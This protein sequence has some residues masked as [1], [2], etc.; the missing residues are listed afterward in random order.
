MKICAAQIRP[1]K[2]DIQTNIENHKRLIELAFSY[3][4]DTIIFP[5]LSLTGY[6]P[7]LAKELAINE[8]D[9][10]LN[11]FQSMSDD[12]GVTIGVGVP[13]KNNDGICISMILFHPESTRQV[14]S[15]KYLHADE[16]PF[17]VSGR[18][19]AVLANNKNNIALAICYE[20]SVPEHSS[21]AFK[22]GA[23]IYMASV[24][25]SAA[26]I[27]KA[28]KSLSG[29]AKKYSMIALMANCIGYCD[30][31]ESGGKTSVWDSKGLLI[32]QMN[33]T[34]EGII[35]V[36]TDTMEII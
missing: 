28:S 34:D 33:D 17:F 4:A 15:K 9:S 11:E 26:G 25:K 16:E 1:V 29:I 30:N 12:S 32:G 31:F 23:E 6:E 24:A 8:N 27:E 13:T 19:A 7:A 10:R 18:N 14:Y 20:L 3:Q 35:M 36:N 22:M 5:E 21:N 2:G